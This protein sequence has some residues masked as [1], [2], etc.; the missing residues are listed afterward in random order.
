[1]KLAHNISI[2]NHIL[3]SFLAL[4]YF[5]G[6][7][8]SCCFEGCSNK[9]P[10]VS[11]HRFPRNDALCKSWKEAL[12]R[13]EEWLPIGGDRVCSAHFNPSEIVLCG[14]SARLMEG[15]VPRRVSSAKCDKTEESGPGLEESGPGLEES[16]PG[17]E[18]S[19]PGTEESGPG[20]EESGP[21]PE[22]SGSDCVQPHDHTYVLP[23]SFT[24]KRRLDFL[25]DTVEHQ[26]N[27]LKNCQERE[28][29]LRV[30][31]ASMLEKL[32]E[33][34][35]LNE[36]A[37]IQLEAYS[38]IPADLF[39]RPM[40]E[41]TEEQRD[42]WGGPLPTLESVLGDDAGRVIEYLRRAGRDDPPVDAVTA[43]PPA[44]GPA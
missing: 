31:L 10:N 25:V 21:G 37:H 22:E 44:G 42:L 24:L 16:G 30:S 4:V 2:L 17:P 26:K 20:L 12:G 41:Y 38:E 28:K 3:C 34:R 43:D 6:M 9:P 11:F 39:N 40:R 15:A 1:M 36:E 18:E 7:P 33:Q 8:N 27:K 23:D 5:I 13:P 32:K 29:R 14:R 35:A 19:G